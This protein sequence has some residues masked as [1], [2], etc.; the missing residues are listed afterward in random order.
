MCL[1]TPPLLGGVQQNSSPVSRNRLS[2][3]VPERTI[4]PT[5]SWQCFPHAYWRWTCSR[6]NT[7][8]LLLCHF[9]CAGTRPWR[10][11]CDVW[12]VVLQVL[13]L[14]VHLRFILY[15]WGK[16][17][18]WIMPYCL[19]IL[20]I[21]GG[22]LSPAGPTVC[23]QLAGKMWTRKWKVLTVMVLGPKTNQRLCPLNR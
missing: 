5:G 2:L 9:A 13:P 8:V 16:S 3:P 15:P 19:Q 6:W 11:N 7:H 21:P 17:L 10:D 1:R 4:C 20:F 23:T 18:D 12:L 22:C 14:V